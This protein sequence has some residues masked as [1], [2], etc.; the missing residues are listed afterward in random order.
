MYYLVYP[1]QGHITHTTGGQ[2]D[3]TETNQIHNSPSGQ[4]IHT[5]HP[6][7]GQLD[8]T[9]TNQ[10]HNSPSGQDIYDKL[11]VMDIT[12]ILLTSN[13]KQQSISVPLVGNM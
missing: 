7:G 9:E 12:G 4:D 13:V 11:F 10:I 3:V 5:T 6:T 8:V 2:L 1:L